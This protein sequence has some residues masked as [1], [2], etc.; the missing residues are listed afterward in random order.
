M[1]KK[2]KRGFN[3]KYTVKLTPGKLRTSVGWTNSGG[4]YGRTHLLL[5]LF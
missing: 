3:G 4:L 5:S 1:L 2:F